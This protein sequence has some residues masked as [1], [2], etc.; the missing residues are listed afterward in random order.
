MDLC[1][2]P[3]RDTEQELYK[4]LEK[5]LPAFQLGNN[6]TDADRQNVKRFQELFDKISEPPLK[7]YYEAVGY[8]WF[9]WLKQ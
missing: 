2:A 6:R 8:N 3:F 7:P 9:H 1:C 5:L 4:T